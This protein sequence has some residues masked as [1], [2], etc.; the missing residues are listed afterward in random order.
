[1]SRI[2]TFCIQLG[3]L[4]ALLAA[5]ELGARLFEPYLQGPS[6]REVR[7]NVQPYMM[8]T[9]RFTQRPAWRNADTDERTPSTMTFNNFGFTEAYDFSLVPDADFIKLHGKH[10]G[11]KLVLLTGGSAAAGNGATGNDTTIA[12]RLQHHLSAGS[13][14]TRYRVI[15]LA[16]GSWSS[17]QQFIG[18]SLFGL[19]LNPDWIVVMDGANDAAVACPQGSGA[20]YPMTWPKFL[21]LTQYGGNVYSLPDALLGHSALLRIVTGQRPAPPLPSKLVYDESDPDRRFDI[22]VAGLTIAEEDRQVEFYL[23]SQ[24]NVMELFHRAN[25]VF[26]TQPQ[27]YDNAVAASYRAALRPGAADA[28]RAK[29]TSE[30]DAYMARSRTAACD[31]KANFQPQGYFMGRSSLRMMQMVAEAKSEIQSR[32]LVYFNTESLL[33][34]DLKKRQPL[35][36][37]NLHLTDLGQDRLGAIYAT[38]I[39]SADQ[40]KPIDLTS[41]TKD[42]E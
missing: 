25:V 30:L 36:R 9:P 42:Q 39:L 17:Y 29:L 35:F 22:K 31:P 10:D 27:L 5:V 7:L 14:G 20:G 34:L 18:L 12:A 15:N 33:P 11:E 1:M 4:V 2:K 16:M 28:T 6:V 23:H 32:R 26:S 13:G 3:I 40:A 37:D 24:L 38:A 41:F 8:F 19:P 21:Y